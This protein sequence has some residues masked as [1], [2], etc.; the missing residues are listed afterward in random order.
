MVRH[1]RQPRF[2]RM[3]GLFS[4]PNLQGF[5]RILTISL[6]Q[7][8]SMASHCYEEVSVLRVRRRSL[9]LGRV[10]QRERR[11]SSV[12]MQ[13]ISRRYRPIFRLQIS[14][15]RL[16]VKLPLT[17]SQPLKALSMISVQP[18]AVRGLSSIRSNPRWQRPA[19]SSNVCRQ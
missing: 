10:L 13:R 1:Q 16:E 6:R 14:T 18:F 3:T 12:W 9:I 11:L 7:P 15:A 4:V 5:V 2:R 8:N 19:P 17:Q